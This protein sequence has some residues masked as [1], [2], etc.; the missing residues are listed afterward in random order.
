MLRRAQLLITQRRAKEAEEVLHAHLG[1]HPNDLE[2]LMSL[3]QALLMQERNKAALDTADHIIELDPSWSPGYWAKGHVLMD[4]NER[5]EARV[6][7]DQAIELDPEDPDN[8]G[9]SAQLYARERFWA[10]AIADA[11]HGLSLDPD[12]SVCR[13]VLSQSLVNT[14]EKGVAEESLVA[15]LAN[16]PLDPDAHVQLGLQAL[17][18]GDT[19][20]ALEAFEEA[21]RLDPEHE[22]ARFGLVEAL[23]ARN[24]I[25]SLILRGFLKLNSLPAK[26]TL[27]LL[28][29]MFVLFRISRS[30]S[31]SNPEW[32]VFLDPITWIYLTFVGLAWFAESFFDVLLLCKREGRLALIGDS[33]YRAFAFAGALTVIAACLLSAWLL[34]DPGWADVAFFVLV[35]QIPVVSAFQCEAE[36]AR[37][38]MMSIAA[39]CN[40]MI[41]GGILLFLFTEAHKVN[42]LNLVSFAG[43]GGALSSWLGMGFLMRER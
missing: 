2:A 24:P 29:G 13:H 40:V 22:G 37:R 8:Y 4:M 26:T 19:E 42:G 12:H 5:K 7:V 28:I 6:M 39:I 32:K 16:N 20:R 38:V 41:F 31:R 11:R 17:H 9:L 36:G 21:L 3:V 10:D 27:F 33:R 14:G 23:K 15:G 25:Y 30:L 35:A 1:Q 43:I 34:S 18:A